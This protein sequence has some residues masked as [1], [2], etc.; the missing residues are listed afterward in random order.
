M[1]FTQVSLRNPVFATMVMLAIVVLGIFSYQR[2]QVDQFPNIDFPVVVVYTAYPGASPEIVETDVSKKI[3]ETLNT[4]SGINAIT[5]RSYQGT[6]VVIAEFQLSVESRKAAEDVREKIAQL[7]ASLRDDVEE[8]RVLRFD[9]ASRP[10]FSLAIISDA[11]NPQALDEAQTT[12][13]A[14]QVLR[15]KLE[16]VRGVGAVSLV[17]STERAIKIELNTNAMRALGVGT[18]QVITAI[19][20]DNQNLPVGVLSSQSRETV[21]QIQARIERPEDF[22]NIIVTKRGNTTIR[23][24]QVANITDG[25]Q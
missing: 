20:S 13:W 7:K 6:S 8:P 9:P 24:N 19:R 18:E 16:N 25:L 12:A 21:V 10:I 5:S 2:L 11:A 3:E 15:K 1:W 4:V 22:A 14:D 23:L 17:G